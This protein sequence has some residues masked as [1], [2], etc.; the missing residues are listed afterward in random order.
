MIVIVGA[1]L[2]VSDWPAGVTVV[3]SRLLA[4]T[5]TS[6]SERLL[7]TEGDTVFELAR[8]EHTWQ[9]VTA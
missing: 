8:W 6:M 5:L 7:P 1:R 2:L 9:D 3:L 4:H